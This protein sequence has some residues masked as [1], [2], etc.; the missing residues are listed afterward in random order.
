V[1]ITGESGVGKEIVAKQIFL[2][3]KTFNN[4]FFTLNCTAIP[5]NLVESELFGY[6]KGAFTGADKD[7]PGIVDQVDNGTLFLDEI[8]DF[9]V[10]S[11]G[12]LLRLIENNEYYKL[13]S[14]EKLYSEF[15]L[16]TATNMDLKNQI[17][18]KKFRKDLFYRISVVNIIIPPLRKRK[19]DIVPL[20]KYFLKEFCSKL[21]KSVPE[22]S[23]KVINKL[24]EYNFPGNVRE[25]RNIIER[26]LIFD[27]NGII[28]DI[29]LIPEKTGLKKI[30]EF[31]NLSLNE[32]EKQYILQTLENNDHNK[33]KTAEILGISRKTLWSKLKKYN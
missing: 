20:T 29:E 30:S 24:M 4:N 9:P 7:K 14:S 25:L 3:S 6:K 11:Q 27:N 31:Q 1:L 21:K 8:G 23:D 18:N 26:M 22:L 13:G 12:K 5:E 16:I 2:K 10:Q 32:L 33:T 19:Q 15:R 17:E 28:K